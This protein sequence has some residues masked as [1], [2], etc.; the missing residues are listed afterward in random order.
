MLLLRSCDR[1][2]V[3]GMPACV[4]TL[5][6]A[7]PQAALLGWKQALTAACMGQG[8]T[9]ESHLLQCVALTS[10]NC[11]LKLMLSG[12]QQGP[13]DSDTW[14]GHHGGVHSGSAIQMKT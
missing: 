2:T 11:T 3:R 1:L 13:S 9:G 5:A 7:N 6:A 14:S 8:I 4:V 12:K 10:T